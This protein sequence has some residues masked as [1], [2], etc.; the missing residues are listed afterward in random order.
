MYKGY[1]HWHKAFAAHAAIN[2]LGFAFAS[3]PSEAIYPE[4]AEMSL[5]EGY[6][7]FEL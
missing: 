3:K 4:E 7:G 6:A 5:W 1:F 2:K